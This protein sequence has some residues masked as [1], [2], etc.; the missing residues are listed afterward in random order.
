MVY[1]F[2]APQI[3]EREEKEKSCQNEDKEEHEREK[4]SAVYQGKVMRFTTSSKISRQDER[5]ELAC[6]A[7]FFLAYT[8]ANASQICNQCTISPRNA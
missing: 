5:I 1:K 4:S 3:G 8:A 7:G 6:K 2:W